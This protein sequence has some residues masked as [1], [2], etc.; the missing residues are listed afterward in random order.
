MTK[1]KARLALEQALA[2]A[3]TPESRAD[4]AFK[5]ARVVEAEGRERGRKRRA[6][7][8]R[9]KD[10]PEPT[11]RDDGNDEFI[12]EPTPPSPPP[13]ELTLAQQKQ[14]LR[15]MRDLG[16][17]VPLKAWEGE[18]EPPEPAPAPAAPEPDGQT[19]T[20]AAFCFPSPSDPFPRS[21]VGPLPGEPWVPWCDDAIGSNAH[22]NED[23]WSFKRRDERTGKVYTTNQREERERKEQESRYREF[24]DKV[25]SK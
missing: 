12:H 17:D 23:G 22:N 10:A 13:P 4:I 3:T 6:R 24:A 15:D 7:A 11:P 14:I 21:S 20:I 18:P 9:L 16:M 25:L 8:K 5:L 2:E 1:S 19:R